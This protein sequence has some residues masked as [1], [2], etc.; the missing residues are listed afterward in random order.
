MMWRAVAMDRRRLMTCAVGLS[1]LAFAPAARATAADDGEKKKKSGGASYLPME[2]VTAT[3]VR[4][5]GH[6]GVFTIEIGLDVPD[7]ALR[8]RVE[9]VL[10]RIRAAYVQS[11]QIYAAGLPPAT[12]PNADYLARELQR[13]TDLALGR[14]GARVL[15]GTILVN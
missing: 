1:A 13:Q 10:P 9:K 12:P 2:T 11:V 5:D 7:A 8:D 15:L 14:P 4:G 6:H 3:L